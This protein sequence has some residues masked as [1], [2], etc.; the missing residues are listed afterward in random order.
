MKNK[1]DLLIDFEKDAEKS[2]KERIVLNKPAIL[3]RVNSTKLYPSNTTFILEEWQQ[4]DKGIAISWVV[5][6]TAVGEALIAST[7]KGVC[8]LGFTNGDYAF[9]LADLQRRFPGSTFTEA[10][11][12]WQKEATAYL[13]NPELNLPV[14][15]HLK[16]TGFQLNVWRKLTLIPFGGLSTYAE[17]A[18]STRNA[19]ATG[20]AVGANP[21]S[22]ILPCH[23]AVRTDGSFDRYYWGNEIKRKLLVYEDASAIKRE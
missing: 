23:R 12:E 21:V 13:N 5:T 22:Y 2:T 10:D 6:D 19:R 20:T 8:F 15:L 16:G 4:G 18:G 3:K 14:H 1:A 9:A 11:T 7:V 17:L